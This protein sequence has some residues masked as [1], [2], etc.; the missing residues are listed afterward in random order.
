MRPLPAGDIPEAHRDVVEE[1]ARRYFSRG[2]FHARRRTVPRC[3]LA[4]LWNPAERDRPSNDRA[5][6]R[7]ER[8]TNKVYLAEVLEQHD[9]PT[10][11]TLIVSPARVKRIV[12]E[13]GLPVALKQ[14]DSAFS[15]G[16]IKADDEA[17]LR[18]A[19]GRLLEKSD[20]IVAQEFIA[21]P[22]DWRIG[23][24]D[25]Q[26]LYACKYFM[27][28]RHWQ[29]IDRSG[30]RENAGRA[31]CIPL[32]AVPPNVL[33][34]ALRAAHLMGDGLYGVD[35]KQRGARCCVIEVNDN[36]SIDAGVEDGVLK[37]DLYRR[38]MEVFLQ[39]VE[40]QRLGAR[41]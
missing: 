30:A 28:R 24:L 6:E 39:R 26:P 29:I 9:V 12:P 40:R 3:S 37:G 16:V 25:R 41:R 22:F 36:P 27:A 1:A 13:L 18:A 31:E 4:I 21:T 15:Q 14:P 38:V 23:V 7:F 20:L 11:Q 19:V 17:T 8:C 33:R 2:R 32:E 5:L 34:M 35:L 10:P